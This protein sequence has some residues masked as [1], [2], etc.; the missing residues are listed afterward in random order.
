MKAHIV[1]SKIPVHQTRYNMLAGVLLHSGKSFLVV[2]FAMYRLSRHQRLLHH[3]NHLTLPLLYILYGN[4]VNYTGIRILASAL[5]K[6][7][8]P[9]QNHLIPFLFFIP[10]TGYHLSL[11]FFSVAVLII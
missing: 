10:L 8:R 7:Y 5:R 11:K 9:V 6:K 2:D 4:T 1:I 3:M